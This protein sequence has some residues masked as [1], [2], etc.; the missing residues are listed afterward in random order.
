MSEPQKRP[1]IRILGRRRRLSRAYAEM[2]YQLR[3]EGDT[4]VR[5]ALSTWIGVALGCLPLWG[6]HF[7]LCLFFARL[8]RLNAAHAYLAAHINNPLTAP[9]IFFGGYG[10]GQRLMDGRWPELSLAEFDRT[11][12]L[13]AGR[14]LL[15]GSAVLGVVLGAILALVTLIIGIVFAR[16]FFERRLVD[17][18]SLPYLQAGVFH[19]EFVRGKLRLDPVYR[20]IMGSGLLPDRGRLVDL[21][22]GRGVLLALL[23]GAGT[24]HVRGEWPDDLRPPPSGLVSSGI[25]ARP[26]LARVARLVLGG[27]RVQNGDLTRVPLPRAEVF[28]LFDVLHYLTPAQQVRVLEV[29]FEGLCP[30]GLLL[31]RDADAAGGWRFLLTRIAERTCS[32]ARGRWRA[33]FHYRRRAEWLELLDGLGYACETQAMYAGTPYANVLITARRP[34]SVQV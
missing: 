24:L 34:G 25:E 13:D 33:A 4:P 11:N 3:T 14:N 28:V 10:I 32:L 1:P 15:V 30:G 31:L 5:R 26:S 29:V 20:W 27:N 19:W 7:L 12:L 17:T 23:D 8:F 6:V 21:G 2:H 22:C 9:L 18:A 16:S